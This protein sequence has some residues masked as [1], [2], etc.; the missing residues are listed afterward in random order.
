MTKFTE[1][2]RKEEVLKRR[3]AREQ[4][5]EESLPR[6]QAEIVP[7]WKRTIREP[8]L[9]Q[10]WWQGIPPKLRGQLWEKAVGNSLQLSKGVHIDY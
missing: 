7:D 10:L 3:R 4:V 5:I 6:W 2:K 1:E 8:S 9:R